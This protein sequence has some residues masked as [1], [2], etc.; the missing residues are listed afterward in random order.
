M[1]GVRQPAHTRDPLWSRDHRTLSGSP[2]GLASG[3]EQLDQVVACRSV[4]VNSDDKVN[5]SALRKLGPDPTNQL[6]THQARTQRPHQ[7]TRD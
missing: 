1:W 5:P 3:T 2:A 4:A 6:L 7:T